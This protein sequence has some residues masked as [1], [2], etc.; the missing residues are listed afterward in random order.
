[1]S[2]VDVAAGVSDA[3]SAAV[4]GAG[5]PLTGRAEELAVIARIAEAPAGSGV[6]LAGAAGV[7][8]TR[9]ALEALDRA[10]DRGWQCCYVTATES[11]RSIPLGA[12]S[13][14]ATDFGSD[15]LRRVQEVVDAVA[16]GGGHRRVVVGVDDAHLLDEMSAVVVHQ[17]VRRR[18]ASVVV[19]LRTGEDVPE[20]ITALWKDEVLP[21]LEVQPL[22]ESE[23]T[24]LVEHVLR[25]RLESSSARRIWHHTRGNVL[26]LRQL[27]ADE[28]AAGRLGE[29]SGVWM[30]QRSEELSP[31]LTEL[32]AAAIGRQPAAVIEVLD[33]LAVADPVEVTVLAAISGPDA[34]DAAEAAGLVSIDTDRDPA[35]VRMV[36]PLFGDVRR[37][38]A[39]TMRLRHLRGRVATGLCALGDRPDLVQRVRRATLAVDSDLAPDPA[40]L[41]DAASAALE[42]MDPAPAERL[43]AAA[44]R[45]GGGRRAQVVHLRALVNCDRLGDA[46]RLSAELRASASTDSHRTIATLGRVMMLIQT[47]NP[48]DAARELDAVR[49]SVIANGLERPYNC[50]RAVLSATRGRPR[51]A[52]D[53]ATAGLTG[54]GWTHDVFE[55]VGLTSLVIGLAESGRF[56]AVGDWVEKGYALSRA[57]VDYRM[58]RFVVGLVH[59]HACG[60]AGQLT[61]GDAVA[62][63]LALEPMDHPVALAYRALLLGSTALDRGDLALARRWFGEAGATAATLESVWFSRYRCRVSAICLAMAGDPS[64]ASALLHADPYPADAP[65]GFVHLEALAHSWVHAAAGATSE[66]IACLRRFAT[67]ARERGMSAG[68]V[69]CLQT[70]AQ[71]GDPTGAERLTELASIGQG[72]RASTAARHAVAL[73]D[74]DGTGLREAA[75]L[76]EAFGD[77]VAAADAAA[78]AAM[79]FRDQ[80]RRGA[81]MTA[82]AVARR[83]ADETGADTPALRANATPIPLTPRQREILALAATGLSNR[84]IADRLVM[85]VRTVEGHLFRAHQKTGVS[86]R[87]E[88]IAL[89]ETN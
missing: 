48:D 52:V 3:E 23:T 27:I 55:L 32:V 14:Y 86:G 41:I 1:M 12:F 44:V 20:A 70:A 72:P 35:V 76:Y 63:R 43:A 88:L 62:Q 18:L 85:S 67:H 29:E 47:W 19:A 25:G 65:G 66:A 59:V 8:K 34:I 79:V 77:R 31:T 10:R 7:G 22:A 83:L 13:D 40:Q 21:R 87:E 36:H 4:V 80:G 5:W 51:D 74:R 45:A 75:S 24:V 2:I 71:F 49:E 38:R 61:D 84:Q 17:L 60:L 89:L 56:D 81:A 69:V 26:Y 73:R 50:T 58:L 37:A 28:L 6:V 42:L 64:N 57:T 9:L 54:P 46:L 53:I 30:W 39:G 68:E 78:Q 15:P 11:A 16:G 33:I 82:T